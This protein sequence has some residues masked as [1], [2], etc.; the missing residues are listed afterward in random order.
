MWSFL[1]SLIGGP[2]V[3]GLLDAYKAKLGAA[4]NVD[5]HAVDLAKASI[6]ADIAARANAKEIR[7]A[8]AGDLGVRVLFFLLGAAFTLHVAAICIGTT[9]APLLS[10]SSWLLHIPPL[11]APFDAY[12]ATIIGFFFG[13]AVVMTGVQ[14]I[15]GALARRA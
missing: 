7:L 4:D 13:S 15:A 14:A 10:S 8:T 5:T 11:P 1:A 9:F 2:V 12:E 3:N 6:A